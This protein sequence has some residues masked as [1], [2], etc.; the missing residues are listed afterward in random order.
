MGAHR[1]E[2]GW[3]RREIWR[4]GGKQG[5]PEDL[6]SPL[7]VGA[8]SEERPQKVCYR[9]GDETGGLDLEE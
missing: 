4:E 2:W 7:G 6:V 3:A 8:E 5:I 9:A 1:Q